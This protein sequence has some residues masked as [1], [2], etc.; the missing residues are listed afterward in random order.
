MTGARIK[1]LGLRTLI[2]LRDRVGDL[3]MQLAYLVERIEREDR[4]Q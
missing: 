2:W 1:L 3:A 4:S